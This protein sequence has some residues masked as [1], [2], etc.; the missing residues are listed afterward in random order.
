MFGL[1]C[2]GAMLGCLVREVASKQ[3]ACGLPPQPL[4]V[5]V[6]RLLGSVLFGKAGFVSVVTG[7][8]LHHLVVNRCTWR[9]STLMV[10]LA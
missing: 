2:L 3:V 5:A 9:R 6:G 10:H 7:G 4:V 1:C 8:L